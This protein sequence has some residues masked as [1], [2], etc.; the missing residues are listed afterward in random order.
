MIERLL[1]GVEHLQN[2]HPLFVHYPIGLLTAAALFYVAAWLLRRDGLATAGFWMLLAGT[3]GGAVAVGTGLYAERGV[4]V[5]RSVRAALLERHE[6]LMLTTA[7]LAVIAC[8]WAVIARPFPHR[9]R[10]AFIL[11][12]LAMVGVMMKGA[13]DGGRMVYDYNAGGDACGQPIEF[14][15]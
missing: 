8:I 15:K 2:T 12:L 5:A 7:A 1:P 4:M 13:D 14:E 11:L 6:A 3:A 10:P 9:L